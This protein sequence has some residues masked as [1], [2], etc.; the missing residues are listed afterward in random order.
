MNQI[1]KS[2][3]LTLAGQRKQ[4][5]QKKTFVLLILFLLVAFFFLLGL[6]LGSSDLSLSDSFLAI[7][8]KGEG[9]NVRIVQKIRLPRVLAGLLAGMG[10]ALSGLAMQ[11]CL[12]NPMA[13]P[14]TLGVSN[15]AVLGANLG[16][17]ILSGG[18]IATNSNTSWNLFNP[19]AVSTFS[20]LFAIGSM[21]LILFLSQFQHFSPETIILTG[22]ALSSLF[23]AI[24]TILQYFATD[25]QLSSAVYWTFGDLGRASFEDDYILLGVV[26]I[27]FVILFLLRY[28]LNALVLGENQA[29]S[30]G[31]NTSF[32]RFVCLLLSSLMTAVSI[33]FLG[34]IGFVGLIAPHI[35]R[36][37]I[38]NDHRFLL[39]ASAL[40][41]ALILLLS[42]TL[43]R[44]IMRGMSLPVGAVTSILGAPFFLYL[45]FLSHRK[46]E[47]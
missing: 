46:E 9:I 33:S 40:C 26:S 1:K 11:T 17:L 14:G 6:L 22:V 29:K 35:M 27:S 32:V 44:V 30:L 18:T 42:D 24:T 34:I 45:V 23:Q 37:I 28:P 38:G 4:S 36:R 7:F 13:S 19:Y 15:A 16:I 21:V 20:F 43:A 10:L 12:D 31:V 3:V 5:V 41:G 25:T 8:G 2:E 39:P 47:H